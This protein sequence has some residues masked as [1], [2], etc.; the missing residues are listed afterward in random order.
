MRPFETLAQDATYALRILRQNPGFAS[1]AILSLALGIGANT[2][3]FSLIDTVLF[4]RWLELD[5]PTCDYH[6]SVG[7]LFRPAR[8]HSRAGPPALATIGLMIVTGIAGY[9]PALRATRVD[10]LIALR[11][12]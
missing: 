9:V 8:R 1:V 3:I 7:Q 2:A 10:P 11:H 4:R 12:K 5:R 6:S